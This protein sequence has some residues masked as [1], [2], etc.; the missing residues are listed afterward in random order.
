MKNTEMPLWERMG[1]PTN[2]KSELTD[3]RHTLSTSP[4]FS[5]QLQD[6]LY[7]EYM[8]THAYARN[9]GNAILREQYLQYA[10]ALAELAKKL[11]EET[12]QTPTTEMPS[13]I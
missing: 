12:K 8:A 3:L 13:R 6:F 9:E 4:L 11:F 1:S 2:S 7:S 5:Q 10:N